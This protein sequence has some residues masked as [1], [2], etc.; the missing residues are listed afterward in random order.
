M[1]REEKRFES[2]D[3]LMRQIAKDADSA[4]HYFQM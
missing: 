3:A 2:K 1:L 4:R